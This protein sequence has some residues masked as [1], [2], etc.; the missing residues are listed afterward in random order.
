MI[1]FIAFESLLGFIG[2][3]GAI[4]SI[5]G[6]ILIVIEYSRLKMPYANQPSA[7]FNGEPKYGRGRKTY[8]GREFWGYKI[9]YELILKNFI[10]NLHCGVIA[11]LQQKFLSLAKCK[12]KKIT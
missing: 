5:I 8:R 9:K 2:F 4:S 10:G 6:L 12:I 3:I 7:L 1:F 11:E